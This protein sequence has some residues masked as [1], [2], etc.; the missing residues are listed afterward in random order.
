MEIVR[1]GDTKNLLERSY[2]CSLSTIRAAKDS[3]RCHR[4]TCTP[5]TS[6]G[7]SALSQSAQAS[8]D[9]SIA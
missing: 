1:R 9:S 8:A 3:A 6:S 5:Q 2:S 7:L 4:T